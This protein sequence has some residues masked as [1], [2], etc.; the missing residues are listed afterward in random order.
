MP[1]F[2][3]LDVPLFEQFT[4]EGLTFDDLRTLPPRQARPFLAQGKRHLAH[5]V[6]QL[7]RGT[8]LCT[9]RQEVE[10]QYTD[11]LSA[12]RTAAPGLDDKLFLQEFVQE[13]VLDDAECD[14][15][16]SEVYFRVRDAGEDVGVFFIYN[17]RLRALAAPRVHVDAYGIPGYVFDDTTD[18]AVFVD[19]VFRTLRVFLDNPLPLATGQVMVVV[20]SWRF[21]TDDATHRWTADATPWVLAVENR[22]TDNFDRMDRNGFMS[23]IDKRGLRAA[24]QEAPATR[25]RRNPEPETKS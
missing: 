21:P 22:L 17:G 9:T 15:R 4:L 23:R 3:A 7:K 18:Q 5:M 20:D 24:V 1:E 8:Q 13:L 12:A 16:L 6:E 2:T 19:R 14:P 11:G 10:L 25:V